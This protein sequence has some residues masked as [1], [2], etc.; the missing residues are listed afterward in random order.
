MA[1]A[2]VPPPY[3]MGAPYG[4][5]AP[6]PFG[7]PPGHG[8]GHALTAAPPHGG[9]TATDLALPFERRAPHPFT[10][11]VKGES[12]VVEQR[13]YDR[14]YGEFMRSVELRAGLQLATAYVRDANRSVAALLAQLAADPQRLLLVDDGAPSADVGLHSLIALCALSLSLS[15][16]L[17]FR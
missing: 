15:L 3:M 7:M 9:F 1:M 2:G 10:H 8:H 13:L 17:L 4:H 11:V 6:P 16:S 5:G 12:A 14:G